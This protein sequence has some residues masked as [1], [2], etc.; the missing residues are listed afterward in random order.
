[1]QSL[2]QKCNGLSLK[3]SILSGVKTGEMSAHSKKST[4]RL[5]EGQVWKIDNAYLHIVESGKRVVYYK[6]MR[7]AGGKMLATQMIAIEALAV[8]LMATEAILMSSG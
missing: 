6:M 3:K 1:M 5:A 8:Y 2:L 7:Q 4:P